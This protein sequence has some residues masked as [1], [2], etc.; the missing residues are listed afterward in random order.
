MITS[1]A[2]M[3]TLSAS[4][5]GRPRTIIIIV[6]TGTAIIQIPESSRTRV[7]HQRQGTLRGVSGVRLGQHIPQD[8]R[9]TAN[10]HARD[11]GEFLALEGV[12]I[13]AGFV[14]GAEHRSVVGGGWGWWG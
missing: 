5:V 2:R 11:A 10:H 1:I 12:H 6:I 4:K 13:G 3:M 9:V 14:D 7:H 8:R